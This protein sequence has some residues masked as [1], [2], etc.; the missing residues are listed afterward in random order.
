MNLIVDERW[1]VLLYMNANGKAFYRSASRFS[2]SFGR[3]VALR[4]LL[5][6]F[7]VTQRT[8]PIDPL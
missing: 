7:N 2:T 8:M 5:L 6:I 4:F 3:H 1:A